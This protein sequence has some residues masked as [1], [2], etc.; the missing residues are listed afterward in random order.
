MTEVM[1]NGWESKTTA[2]GSVIILDYKRPVMLYD[3]SFVQRYYPDCVYEVD[4][5]AEYGGK[6]F[7]VEKKRRAKPH[8][9]PGACLV[10]RRVYAPLKGS[11]FIL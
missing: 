1:K 5:Y 3:I 7:Y 4:I 9:C 10:Q 2:A 6:R 8:Q 11:V